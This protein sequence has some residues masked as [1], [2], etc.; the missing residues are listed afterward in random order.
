MRRKKLLRACLLLVIGTA[1]VGCSVASTVLPSG[2]LD[3]GAIR[4]EDIV[5][6]NDALTFSGEGGEDPVLHDALPRNET[7]NVVTIGNERG[8]YVVDYAVR[9]V[10]LRESNV[11]VR[12]SGHC[13][14]ACTIYL[15]LPQDQTCIAP[16]ASFTFH[17]PNA[18]TRGARQAAETYMLKTYPEWV[19][20]WIDAQGGLSYK[21]VTMS[22]SFAS[23]YLRP[24][25]TV[26]TG[27]RRPVD[28]ASG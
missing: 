9:M 27:M 21:P 23:Q 6:G 18:P 17:K 5:L 3:A 10:E 15:A 7:A 8:G 26:A 28:D 22:Y 11:D 20:T 16:G 14:S 4:G 2:E 13:K 12:F 25:E 1:S 24:C 19:I